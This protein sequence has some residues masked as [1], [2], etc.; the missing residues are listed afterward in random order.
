MSLGMGSEVSKA[1]ATTRGLRPVCLS[2]SL[3]LLLM[4]HIEVLSYCSGTVPSCHHDP[5][6]MVTD[7]PLKL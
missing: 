7:H 2:R 6:M 1:L 4:D 3:G 5:S